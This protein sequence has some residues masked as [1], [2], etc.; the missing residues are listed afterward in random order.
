VVASF[1][2]AATDQVLIV[3]DQGQLIRTPVKDVRVMGR[4]A[5]GVTL[6]RV[7]DNEHVVSVAH[8]ADDGEG[9][10]GEDVTADGA[11]VAE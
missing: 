4:S 7:S 1:P 2:V 5:S 11:G 8:L 10:E 3:S 9:D 6:F